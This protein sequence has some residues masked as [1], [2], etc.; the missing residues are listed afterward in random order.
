MQIMR[1]ACRLA[2]LETSGVLRLLK[3]ELVLVPCVKHLEWVG[4][5]VK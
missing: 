4:G 3:S 2:G 5:K 1:M